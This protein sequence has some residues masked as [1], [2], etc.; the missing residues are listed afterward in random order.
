MTPTT[1]PASLTTASWSTSRRSMVASACSRA[2]SAPA[3]EDA[4]P[5]QARDRDRAEPV[6]V[7]LAGTRGATLEEAD[8]LLVIDDGNGV[9]A[10]ILH[11]DEGC[12]GAVAPGDRHG[13]RA[14]AVADAHG[15]WHGAW[16]SWRDRS[17]GVRRAGG[18]RPRCSSRLRSR[19]PGRHRGLG[20]RWSAPAACRCAS[21]PRDRGTMR[22]SGT[23]DVNVPSPCQWWG[24]LVA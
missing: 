19:D 7:T 24:L 15:S 8:H 12:V 16:S 6:A 22:S 1:W 21:V 4:A 10:S 2:S 18:Q 17:W 20:A 3:H 5:H 14:H 13:T 11:P 9:E 23:K